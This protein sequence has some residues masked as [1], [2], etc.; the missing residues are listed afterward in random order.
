MC[1]IWYYYCTASSVRPSAVGILPVAIQHPNHTY[2]N[3]GLNPQGT[4]LNLN[5]GLNNQ[6]T[7]LNLNTGLNPPQESTQPSAF[8]VPMP[9]TALTNEGKES[10]KN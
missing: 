7:S 6:G 5:T 2:L 4:S 1:Y 9:P 3:T 8:N 10:E